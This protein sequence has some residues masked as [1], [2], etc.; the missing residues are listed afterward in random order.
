MRGV[1]IAIIVNI[2]ILL[3]FK[4][5]VSELGLLVII[6]VVDVIVINTNWGD[7]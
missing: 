4:N 3:A 7:R 5:E 2:G 1:V 6:V